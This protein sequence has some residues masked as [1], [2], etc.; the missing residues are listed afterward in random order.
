MNA[1]NSPRFQ[2]TINLDRIIAPRRQ[3]GLITRKGVNENIM[4]EPQSIVGLFDDVRNAHDLIRELIDIGVRSD[5][6]SLIMNSADGS[7][8]IDERNSVA[9]GA[10]VGGLGGLLVGWTAIALSGIGPVI[11]A[12]WLATS[13]ISAGV[14]AVTGGLIGGL[15]GVGVPDYRAEYYAEG[16]RRGGALVVVR[17]AGDMADRVEAVMRTYGAVDIDERGTYYRESGYTGFDPAAASYTQDEMLRERK[18]RGTRA[19]G[20]RS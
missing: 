3:A 17:N 10:G 18:L 5:D 9:I 7:P 19:A 15:T 13:L 4:A 11:A 14:G 1:Q 16:V 2:I 8:M 20:N 6:I 12:G